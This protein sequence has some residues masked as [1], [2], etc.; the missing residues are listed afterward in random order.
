MTSTLTSYTLIARDLPAAMK[1]K[2]ADPATARETAYYKANI[3]KV[4]SVDD[5]LADKRLYAYA[6]KAFGLEDMTYAKAF[7]RKI[8]TEGAASPSSFANRL[9]DDRYVAFAKAFDFAA[10]RT[11][12][13]SDAIEA[14]ADAAPAAAA[15]LSGA[16]LTKPIDFSGANEARFTLSTP[17]GDGAMSSA[18]IVLNKDTLANV[19]HDLTAVKPTEIFAA[20][21]AQIDATGEAGI[22]GKVKAGLDVLDRLVF[23]TGDYTDLGSDGA[24]PP[25]RDA[26]RDARVRRRAEKPSIS[27]SAPTSPPTSRRRASRKPTCAKPSRPRPAIR[28]RACA[29]PSTSPARPRRSR[30]PT[31]SWA[32]RP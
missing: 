31:T 2:A 10:I 20:I 30:A 22:A 1:R 9:A 11:A 28:I 15:R 14:G 4:R 23:V 27:A 25:T 21:Q 32:I 16:V 3:G 17:L 5:L 26:P 13:G 18:T 8:L 19:A 12:R 24:A 7:M 6:M 29:S